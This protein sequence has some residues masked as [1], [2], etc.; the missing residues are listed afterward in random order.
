MLNA[1]TARQL[2]DWV[3]LFLHYTT[4][5]TGAIWEGHP[6]PHK[7]SNIHDNFRQEELAK[8]Q[9]PMLSGSFCKFTVENEQY[10]AKIFPIGRRVAAPR[11]AEP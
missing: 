11:R 2:V 10:F 6:V 9:F 8:W 1:T 7:S 5:M 4:I 3:R